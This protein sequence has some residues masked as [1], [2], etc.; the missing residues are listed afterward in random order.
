MPMSSW[1]ECQA[2]IAATAVPSP[3]AIS[4]PSAPSTGPADAEEIVVTF[5]SSGCALRKICNTDAFRLIGERLRRRVHDDRLE[6][7]LAAT[8]FLTVKRG[9]SR[10]D[11][12]DG[13]VVDYQH[14]TI[15][16][17]TTQYGWLFLF[18]CKSHLESVINQKSP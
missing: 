13:Y 6:L 14:I 8:A 3:F 16:C 7:L 18:L 5:T 2:S 9:G 1:A 4:T 10:S 15:G 12:K 17:A 11:G